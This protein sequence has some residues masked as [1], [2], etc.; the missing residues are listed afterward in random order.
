LT[1]KLLLTQTAIKM[2]CIKILTLTFFLFFTLIFSH[3][4]EEIRKQTDKDIQDNANYESA[5]KLI[6]EQKTKEGLLKL[7]QSL[8]KSPSDFNKI[9]MLLLAA[10]TYRR[11][12]DYDNLS[13]YLAK[14]DLKKADVKQTL[15]TYK[16]ICYVFTIQ[17]SL[18]SAIFYTEKAVEL[19]KKNQF[20]AGDFYNNLSI[21]YKI[22][23]DSY[24]Q[25]FYIKKSYEEF[26]KKGDSTDI[27]YALFA[28]GDYYLSENQP[29]KAE[30]F[31]IQGIE[32]QKKNKK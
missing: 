11:A 13:K 16:L 10:V 14:I 23:G 25:L 18:D 7:E 31:I 26:V 1:Q 22:K 21:F 15:K 32:L 6:E 27:V 19:C 17:N 4:Q 5:K 9:N 3:A 29:N 28:I 30:K 2:N 20:N 12:G 24:S 8:A